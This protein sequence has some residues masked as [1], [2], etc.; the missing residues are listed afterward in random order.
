MFLSLSD[1]D[2]PKWVVYYYFLTSSYNSGGA[3]TLFEQSAN[4]LLIILFSPAVKFFKTYPT[5]RANFNFISVFTYWLIVPMG[6]LTCLRMALVNGPWHP[7]AWTSCNFGHW[8]ANLSGC[9]LLHLFKFNSLSSGQFRNKVCMK[10]YFEFYE[11]RV[12][13]E[14]VRLKRDWVWREISHP[15]W[16]SPTN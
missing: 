9:K 15:S 12:F 16:N 11:N 8:R 3:W 5:E 6:L 2:K 7:K 4:R 1:K 14:D 10:R 13:Q